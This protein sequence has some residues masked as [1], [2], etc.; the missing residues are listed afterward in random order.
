MRIG[1]LDKGGAGRIP[2]SAAIRAHRRARHVS[3]CTIERLDPESYL[4][5]ASAPVDNLLV[6]RDALTPD[7]VDRAL[8]RARR[9]GSR[10]TVDLD[11]DLLTREAQARL[12]RQG[13]DSARL[14]ALGELV[15]VA[16]QVT[17]STPFLASLVA[18]LHGRRAEMLPNELDPLLWGGTVK[19]V[20]PPAD[21]DLRILYMGSRTH[22][23]DLELLDGVP[24]A[25][26]ARL[27]RRVR[28]EVVGITGAA[29]PEGADRLVPD[30]P[31]Y[32]D[33]V[34][35]LRRHS[36]RWQA[37]VAPLTDEGFNLAKSD[38]KLLEYA[39]LGLG[40]V[41]TPF[42]PYATAPTRLARPA[43]NR[44]EWVDQLSATLDEEP[45]EASCNRSWVL[46][47]RAITPSSAHRWVQL[48]AGSMLPT[49][50]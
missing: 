38:L 16:D 1:I 49:T 9:D 10:L 3:T 13:Y 24:A 32:A 39:A 29:L 41:A 30:K 44:Q 21:D 22:Q 12:V 6:L 7:Q 34:R 37:A 35:W 40:C 5:D 28:L 47:H 27:G 31:H 26:T 33:F 20:P 25:L 43:R 18:S 17:V 45:E 46:R 4:T 50:G 8:R 36:P 11:D 48:L 2:P 15:S 14:T 19:T 42:G 23:S